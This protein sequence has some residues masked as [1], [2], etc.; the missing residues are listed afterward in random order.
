MAS[1]AFASQGE[2]EPHGSETR[3]LKRRVASL[4]NEVEILSRI[5]RINE[6]TLEEISE[7]VSQE[8]ESTRQIAAHELMAQHSCLHNPTA[9]PTHQ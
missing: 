6:A 9:N 7:L 8:L 1:L 3:H 4:E 2:C 5:V